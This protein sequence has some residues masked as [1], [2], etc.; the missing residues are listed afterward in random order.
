L[1]REQKKKL[2]AVI[3]V[4]NARRDLLPSRLLERVFNEKGWKTHVVSKR[5]MR[6]KLREL[7]PDAC[8][9]PRGDWPE[10]KQIGQA[11]NLY[12]IPSEG[13]RLTPETMMSVFL[14]RTYQK[15]EGKDRKTVYLDQTF[16][17]I[18][19][20]DHIRKVFLW[21]ENTR[22]FLLNTGVF[23]DEQLIVAG[24]P[25]LDVY[26]KMERRRR[27]TSDKFTVGVAFSVKATNSFAGPIPYAN[28]LFNMN[29]KEKLPLVPS[30]RHWE[31]YAWRDFAILRRMMWLLRRL[32]QTTDYQIQIRVGPF[33]SDREYRFLEKL[34]PDRI[35]ICDRNEQL[36]DYLENIDAM[37][38]CWSTT[39][40]EA[41]LIGIPVI[42]IPFLIPEEQL[43][44]HVDA[45]ANGFESFL[46][47]YH[48]PHSEDEAVDLLAK[49]TDGQLAA[50]QN[51][52]FF[53]KEMNKLYA[54]PTER[55]SSEMI[56][57]NIIK[58]VA[59]NQVQYRNWNQSMPMSPKVESL[60]RLNGHTVLNKAKSVMNFVEDFKSK[61]FRSN[62]AF[63][64]ISSK[65]VTKLIKRVEL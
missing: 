3:V 46:K 20:F 21:G 60:L 4:D 65:E 10:T 57:D 63:F 9:L 38:T 31:D 41:A 43:Y 39:G 23:R 53:A 64:D 19:N 35:K 55:S 28:L 17:E 52:D 44:F 12:V 26:R 59:S 54:W 1:P 56:V 42:G 29:P 2:S 62:R 27:K 58:D 25:R 13:A 6:L 51:A 14:G 22:Q 7:Q 36:R 5:D 40:L 15:T 49:A 16:K 18:E 45:Y 61:D 33:E 32:L 30:G 8:L 34:Y 47:I 24:N 50:T 48:T 11:T 37:L